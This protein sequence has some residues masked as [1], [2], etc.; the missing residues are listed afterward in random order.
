M[1][2]AGCPITEVSGTI[3]ECKYLSKVDFSRNPLMATVTLPATMTRLRYLEYVALCSCSLTSLPNNLTLLPTVETIDLSKNALSTLPADMSGLKRLKVLILTDNAFESIPDSI[4][5]LGRLDCLEMKRN[6]LNNRRGD[7]WLNVPPKLKILD[8][9]DNCSLFLLPDGLEQLEY[10]EELNLSYC[11]IETLPESLGQVSSLKTIHLAGNKLCT[12]LDSFGRLLNL[13]TLD[14]EGNRRL[15]S[16]PPSLHRLRELKDKAMGKNTGLVLSNTPALQ[17]PDHKIVREGVV[18]VRTDLLAEDCFNHVTVTIATEV[19]DDTII[20]NLSDDIVTIVEGGLPDD[21]MMCMADVAVSEEEFT[22]EI[23]KSILF[24]LVRE[25]SKETVDDEENAILDAKARPV[26]EEL[27]EEIIT[28]TAKSVVLEQEEEWRLGQTVPEQ[29][30][31]PVSFGI[32]A[33]SATVQSLD[34]LA[35]CNLS[36]PPAATEE[37]TSVIS[38]VLNPHGYDRTL[39]LDE[40]ELLV[41]MRPSGMTFSKP[42]KLKIAH[43][44]PKFDKEREYVMMTSEDDGVTWKALETLSCQEKGQA[45][46][47][48]EVAHF[49]SFAVVARM[50]ERCHKVRKGEASELKSS[51]QTGI[52]ISLPQDCVPSEEDIS[53]KVIPVDTE[54]LTCAGME[55]NG[56]EG[57]NGMSHIVRFIKGNKLLLNSPATI[58][59]PLSPGEED[60][61]VR[62][63]SC[64]EDGDWEDVTSKVEDVILEESKVAFKTDRLSSGFTVLRCDKIIDPNKIVALVAKNTRT[65]RVRAVIFKKWKEPREEGVMTA[66]MEC[67]LEELV[68]DRICRMVTKEGYERQEGTPTPTMS[69]MEGET[70]CA[71]FMGSIRPNVEATNSYYGVNFNFYCNRPRIREF[72]V[73]LVDK[74]KGATSRVMLYPGR[75]EIYH[76]PRG[77]GQGEAK[78]LA[79]AQIT[80]PTNVCSSDNTTLGPKMDRT[81]RPRSSKVRP[82][83]PATTGGWTESYLRAQ[84]REKELD[85]SN[86][87]LKEIPQAVFLIEELEILDVSDNPVGSIPVNIASLANLKEMRVAGCPITEVSGTIK[88]CKYLSKVDFSR[89]PLM[90]TVTLPATMMRL[91]YLEYV[92]LCSCSLSSLPDNLTL[93]PTVETID[94]SKNALSTLPADMSGLKRL[95]VLILTDN[96]FESIPDSIMSLGRLDCLE[97]K[98][99]KLNNRRGD[100]WLNVPPKL[101]ILDM[102]DNCS[103]FL[104][105]DGLE[106]LEY[107]EELNLSYCGIETL[108]ESLGNTPAL[109]V[110]DHKIVR[111]GVVSVRTD[112]LAEDCFNHVTVTIATE[113]IDDTIIESLSDDI[114]TIVEGGL[115]DD[116]MMCM[117]DVAVSEEEFTGDIF[118]SIVLEFV[119]EVS[120]ETVEEE[121]AIIDAKA[122]PVMEELVEEIITATAKSVVLEQEE[123]WRLGQTVPE[124]YD[125]PISYEISTGRSTVQSFD[126]PAGCNLSIPPGATDEDTSVITLVLNPHGYDGTIQLGDDQ[127]LV[128]DIIEM[129]PAGMTFSDPVKLRIP[130]SLPKYDS[131][132]EYFVMTSEDDGMTWVD[133]ETQCEHEQVTPVDRDTVACAGMEDSIDNMSHIVNFFKGSNL[134]LNSPA[135][136]VLPLSPGEEDSRV[137]VLSCNEDGDWEDV[138]SK[139]E[140]VVLRGSKV[141]FKTDRLSSGQV[142]MHY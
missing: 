83:T 31:K 72:D 110:P 129:R 67:V 125:K 96:A 135:T 97:M 46:V 134:L 95:K 78:P 44:L 87:S 33:A 6:K 68:E 47:I 120:K 94:L 136:I 99:N 128:S 24:E 29:Y 107:I 48:V 130:H 138:T 30:D 18:S 77:P 36:I 20:E 117:A 84:I 22:G 108:P 66:R 81:R 13:E 142:H 131:E 105:P 58:V 62:V 102:E 92:S 45:Y 140:D 39:K 56:M 100:L 132:R 127:L 37:D 124:E 101:K 27:L 32:S 8:M 80:P 38:A 109:Q 12:L 16:L 137:R 93:L 89:N 91:R 111:E 35:S 104:L 26:M 90:A 11:G 113:V 114:V 74:G 43:S 15:S 49:S 82:R 52:K 21:L 88:E 98:R 55:D 106:Q 9:E 63:L 126:L 122:R 42:V 86:K 69:M 5:S 60:S 57:I 64:N 70:F 71:I 7:L 19:I 54:T 133:L 116:L 41:E 1:R 50:S 112:L 53:F 75:K 65:R 51:K 85:L 115:P 119:R 61:R 17:V 139:V 3:Q 34:L 118:K 73:T 76:P 123:E 25:F 23:F 14:L 40:N 10:I 141:A 103:L 121:N 28:A 4:T 59:L 79:T 2:V